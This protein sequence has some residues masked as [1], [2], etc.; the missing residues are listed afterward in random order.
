MDTKS[1]SRSLKG[2]RNST[3]A[4]D[5]KPLPGVSA[6]ASATRGRPS[7]PAS[8]NSQTQRGGRASR[9]GAASSTRS[10]SPSSRPVTSQQQQQQGKRQRSSSSSPERLRGKGGSVGPSATVSQISADALATINHALFTQANLTVKQVRSRMLKEYLQAHAAGAR[11]IENEWAAEHQSIWQSFLDSSYAPHSRE[12]QRL[13]DYVGQVE[14][15]CRQKL[16]HAETVT[17]CALDGI[18]HLAQRITDVGTQVRHGTS[19][20]E[21]EP[22]ALLHPPGAAPRQSLLGSGVGGSAVGTADE[23]GHPVREVSGVE[24]VLSDPHP[25][26]FRISQ[27]DRDE[28][29]RL[30]H[31]FGS[32]LASISGGV[33][34]PGEGRVDDS[35]LSTLPA[36]RAARGLP[37]SSHS[38]SSPLSVRH[39]E[40]ESLA[41][42]AACSSPIPHPTRREPRPDESVH[43][44]ASG[45]DS[46]VADLQ[47]ERTQRVLDLERE[48]DALG[49]AF[50]LLMNRVQVRHQQY[51]HK[52]IAQQ[53]A[54]DAQATRLKVADDVLRDTVDQGQ[55]E[56]LSAVVAVQQLS[57]ELRGRMEVS[58]ANMDAALKALIEQSA[59][60][61]FDNDVLHEYDSLAIKKETCLY[62]FMSRMERQVVEQADVLRLAQD[63]VVHIWQLQQ[64]RQRHEQSATAT[65]DAEP[66]RTDSGDRTIV[67]PL[68]PPYAARLEACDRATLL[69]LLTRLTKQ[70]PDATRHVVGALDEQDAFCAAHPDEAAAVREDLARTAA[71]VQLL[72]RLDEE[73]RLHSTTHHTNEALALRIRRL[74]EQYDAY[75]D[76]NYDYARA[77]ARQADAERRLYAP[78]TV[79]LFDP[80]TPVPGQRS[81]HGHESSGATTAAA[82]RVGAVKT[83]TKKWDGRGVAAEPT[84]RDAPAPAA[85]PYLS[86]WL[87]KQQELRRRQYETGA[88][89]TGAGSTS[90]GTVVGYLER[91]PPRLTA[92]AVAAQAGVIGAS[93]LEPGWPQSTTRS[94]LQTAIS[95]SA[96][97]CASASLPAP[98]VPPRKG[99]VSYV[100]STYGAAPEPQRA[101]PTGRSEKSSVAMAF[102]DGDHQFIQR[103]RELFVQMD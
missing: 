53:A 65:S 80:R 26:A 49:A 6:S 2:T 70:C 7:P 66:R 63:G 98:P 22:D 84:K 3:A 5:S 36:S 4:P 102:R 47:A 85:L 16:R 96:S 45:T 76:F 81:H 44:D 12:I 40:E 38:E 19:V 82:G 32:V 9:A 34:E 17:H 13:V 39:G 94:R 75:I 83:P 101:S 10:S 30:R 43:T 69:K 20:L 14:S 29:E 55:I 91:H 77:L 99:L 67:T 1:R 93:H 56:S 33:A 73:G 86:L 23:R 18:Q 89:I 50:V 103:E 51:Q 64:Q 71:V 46:S 92:P 58:E 15:T 41:P 57:R 79:A 37:T 24:A 100:L 60:V 95:A 28:R 97:S 74:V 61:C 90:I 27:A 42:F 88:M 59:E 54:L 62:A 35:S 72:Q 78:D 52:I 21:E 31:V 11:K 25:P 48:L 87:S 68:P 8:A